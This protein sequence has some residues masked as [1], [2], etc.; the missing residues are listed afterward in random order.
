M[1]GAEAASREPDLW[2][3]GAAVPEDLLLAAEGA[4][5]VEAASGEPHLR[6][7][8]LKPTGREV[9][10]WGGV[11]TERGRKNRSKAAREKTTGVGLGT[12]YLIPYLGIFIK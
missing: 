8:E 3:A 9:G 12:E 7:A 10:W 4:E 1:E 6:Q 11:G 5:V 2:E